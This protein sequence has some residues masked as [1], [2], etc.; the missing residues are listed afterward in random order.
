VIRVNGQELHFHSVTS[1]N[2]SWPAFPSAG[3]EMGPRAGDVAQV[4]PLHENSAIVL[5]CS[6]SGGRP[7][8]QVRW[9][10]GSQELVSK[11]SL[12]MTE[13]GGSRVTSIVHIVLTR[14]DLSSTFSC[15]VSNNAT[16]RPITRWIMFDVHGIT[17]CLL[18]AP[19]SPVLI[20]SLLSS[21]FS[22]VSLLLR[23]HSN[24]NHN[25][26]LLSLL[27]LCGCNE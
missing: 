22:L 18:A 3:S 21:P 10:N 12:H 2:I 14:D 20:L 13:S 6:T 5:E 23:S 15:Q 24:H 26:R 8:P 4:G 17:T 27:P 16:A 9:L 25:H 7:M 11:T 19:L 1:S